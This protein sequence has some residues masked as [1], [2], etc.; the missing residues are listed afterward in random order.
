[1]QPGYALRGPC[2]TSTDRLL[3]AQAF[4]SEHIESFEQLEL[5]LLLRSDPDGYWTADAFAR[6]T[7]T[8]LP[9][10][11]PALEALQTHGL[12]RV[13][14]AAGEPSYLYGPMDPQLD[15]AVGALAQ[16]YDERPIEIIKLMS[17]N[18]IGRLR[19][20]AIRAFADAFLFRKS[21]DSGNG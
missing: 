8:A 5:L 1:M 19:T 9:L 2:M 15:A 3:V 13:R 12:V 11:M 20:A 16:I 17:A 6:L 7:R 18:A 4:V 10:I 14:A 21:K